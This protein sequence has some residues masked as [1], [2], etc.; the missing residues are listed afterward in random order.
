MAFRLIQTAPIE[1]V[2][3]GERDDIE[4]VIANV[5]NHNGYKTR[6]D[7][8]AAIREWAAT[9]KAGDVFTTYSSVIVAGVG[10]KPAKPASKPRTRAKT[11]ATA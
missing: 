6:L 3:R 2:D 1:I 10:H 11:A 5:F 9:A 4:S 7:M 8:N